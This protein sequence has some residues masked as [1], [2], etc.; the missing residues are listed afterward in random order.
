MDKPCYDYDSVRIK[1]H[2]KIPAIFLNKTANKGIIAFFGTG[3]GKSITALTT[4]R[5]LKLP[6]ILILPPAVIGG[7]E[8]EINRLDEIKELPISIYSYGQFINQYDKIG[9][10]LVNGKLLIM[11]EAHNLRSFGTTTVKMIMAFSHAKKRLLLTGTPLQNEPMDILALLCMIN[12]DPLK[13]IDSAIK[14][15]KSEL[16]Q[17]QLYLSEFENKKR[18]EE[19]E[20]LLE[21]KTIYYAVNLDTNPKFPSVKEKYIKIPMSRAYQ[22][23][24]EIIETGKQKELPADYKGINLAVF[25]NGLR[26]ATN[27][28]KV[29]SPKISSIMKIIKE[30][31]N[32]NRKVIVYSTWQDAG[33]GIIKKKLLDLGIKCSIVSGEE[34]QTAKSKAVKDYNSNINPVI[35]ITKAGAAGLDLKET[36]CVIIMEPHWNE[37]LIK[38]VIGRAARYE[39]HITLP[40]SQRNVTVYRFILYRNDK[41]SVDEII[42]LMSKEK[43]ERNMNFYRLVKKCSFKLI[44]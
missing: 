28:V 24:Y 35:L 42:D 22:H 4:I 32:N 34:S 37:E 19:L 39:S 14:Y 3:T 17:F 2:Q 16:I 29:E 25:Y 6:A 11:D 33:I 44:L 12:A 20:E 9:N 7:F 1:K 18:A 38:Q 5:C 21:D 43:N 13:N 23:E 41:P 8:R 26:R 36:R 40:E 31:L 30:Y 10:K 27:K 15:F